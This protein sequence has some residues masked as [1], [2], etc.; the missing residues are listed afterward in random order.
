MM[1][2]KIRQDIRKKCIYG[3]IVFNF[4][5]QTDESHCTRNTVG[6]NLIEYTGKVSTRMANIT[7]VKLLLSITVSTPG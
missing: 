5:P 3:H 4:Q 6:G 2:D 7:T 1:Y